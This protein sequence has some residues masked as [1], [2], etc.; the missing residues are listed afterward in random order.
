MLPAAPSTTRQP[1]GSG[2]LPIQYLQP[3]DSLLL[4]Y[5]LSSQAYGSEPKLDISR[6][7]KGR[8]SVRNLNRV[9]KRCLPAQN[10]GLLVETVVVLLA[11][12][13][14]STVG[15]LSIMVLSRP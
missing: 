15:V 4:L 13:V 7:A 5:P 11:V 12:G 14:L 8:E 1:T 10:G 6:I 2:A 3:S 9:V